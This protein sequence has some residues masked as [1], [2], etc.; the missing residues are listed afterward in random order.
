VAGLVLKERKRQKDELHWPGAAEYLD[1]LRALLELYKHASDPR[2]EQI[3]A[4]D[5]VAKYSLRKQTGSLL[6]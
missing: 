4:L 1:I 6:T 5:Q 3:D 2:Q